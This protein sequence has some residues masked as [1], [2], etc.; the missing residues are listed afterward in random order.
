MNSA[1]LVP[2]IQ[3]AKDSPK[4]ATTLAIVFFA[5]VLFGGI[6]A[7]FG[8]TKRKSNKKNATRVSVKRKQ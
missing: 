5:G 3:A 7:I 8:N 4:L 1:T 2:V 6:R